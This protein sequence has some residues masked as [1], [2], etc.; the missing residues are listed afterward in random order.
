MVDHDSFQQLPA[1]LESGNT[2]GNVTS[3]NTENASNKTELALR[4]VY[5]NIHYQDALIKLKFVFN[6]SQIVKI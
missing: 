5:P 6:V 4:I 1:Q 3:S 2:L